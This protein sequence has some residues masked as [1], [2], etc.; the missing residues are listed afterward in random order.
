MTQD[1]QALIDQV[2]RRWASLGIALLPGASSQ[3]VGEFE[4]LHGLRLPEELSRYF[5]SFGGM[6]DNEWDND[7]VRF[8]GLYELTMVPNAANY[9]VF[10]DWS[11]SAHEYAVRISD[12]GTEVV[13]LYENDLVLI[14]PTFG[15]FL[16]TYLSDP[17]ALFPEWVPSPPPDADPNC[18]SA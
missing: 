1:T 18:P 14:A 17:E 2:K 4:Q 6:K 3:A 15:A 13:V 7:L 11:L 10:A 16:Q 5:R 9:F 12:E 8:W